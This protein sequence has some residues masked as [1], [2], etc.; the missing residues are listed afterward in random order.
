MKRDIN[1][2]TFGS[3]GQSERAKTADELLQQYA[4]AIGD[5]ESLRSVVEQAPQQQAQQAITQYGGTLHHAVNLYQQLCK[6]LKSKRIE[7]TLTEDDRDAVGASN[8]PEAP[9]SP[10]NQTRTGAR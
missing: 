6:L 2:R 3:R 9:G 10:S 5:C 7:N 4:A 1:S 8:I